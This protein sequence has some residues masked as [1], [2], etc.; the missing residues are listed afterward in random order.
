MLV[1]FLLAGFGCKSS[2]TSST[3][4]TTG[5]NGA[6]NGNTTTTFQKGTDWS[7]TADSG[8]GSLV[9]LFVGKFYNNSVGY[10]DIVLLTSTGAYVYK[11]KIPSSLNGWDTS[12][13]Q[14]SGTEASYTAGTAVDLSLSSDDVLDLV[15]Y[16][17]SPARFE[18]YINDGKASFSSSSEAITASSNSIAAA[19][20][21]DRSS[22]TSKNNLHFLTSSSTGNNQLFDIKNK[23]IQTPF[24]QTAVTIS[25]GFKALS[26]DLNG[27][28]YVDFVLVPSN[29]SSKIT[30]LKNSSDSSFTEDTTTISRSSSNTVRDALLGDFNRDG[31]DDL[32]LATSAGFELY[33]NESTTNTLAFSSHDISFDTSITDEISMV[34]ANLTEDTYYDLIV[35]RDEK[36]SVFFAATSDYN[37]K[38]I[39]STA[40]SPS[41]LSSDTT[42]VRVADVDQDRV[43]DII[44]S[45]A[46]GD[47][48]TFFNQASDSTDADP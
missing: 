42:M 43:N 29:G 31:L 25:T 10:P 27:D 18:V 3:N 9:D 14:I 47:I 34:Y 8:M 2:T 4:V 23:T 12:L 38:D 32:L 21:K 13:G 36:D 15:L 6:G 7:V 41:D 48:T 28:G 44:M 26:A 16:R 33:V 40:F 20:F 39:T 37:F 11:N 35:A 1:I 5:G 17:Q 22:N 24:I 30:L 45:D 19:D 46:N